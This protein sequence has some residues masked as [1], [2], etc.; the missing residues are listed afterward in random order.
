MYEH[1]LGKVPP[2]DPMPDLHPCRCGL[3]MPA[4]PCGQ[5]SDSPAARYVYGT[6]TVVTVRRND[7][8]A[9]VLATIFFALT[10]LYIGV[11]V[12]AHEPPTTPAVVLD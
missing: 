5:C 6:E 8:H 4:P 2:V 3:L 12:S 7:G 9:P 11:Q 10:L 1:V